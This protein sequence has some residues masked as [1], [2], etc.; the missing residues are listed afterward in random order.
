MA[1]LAAST[2][3][4]AVTVAEVVLAELPGGIATRLENIGNTWVERARSEQACCNDRLKDLQEATVVS[5]P[6]RFGACWPRRAR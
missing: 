1:K 2:T 6:V 4:A 3:N 5:H